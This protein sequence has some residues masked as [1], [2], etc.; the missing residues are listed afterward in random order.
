[1][2]FVEN[3]IHYSGLLYYLSMIL[4]RK[5]WRKKRD[6]LLTCPPP[7]PLLAENA[8]QSA[9]RKLEANITL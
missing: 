3:S 9:T 4:G 5:K 2:W 8:K 6:L 1:M 7:L